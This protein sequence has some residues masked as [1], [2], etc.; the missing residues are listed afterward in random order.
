M[1]ESD[2]NKMAEPVLEPDNALPETTLETLPEAVREAA[3]R[4]GWP[5][6]M[7]VQAKAIPYLLQRRDL[8]VQSRTGSGKTG[9]YVLPMV[10]QLDFASASCQALVLTPTREL[11]HQVAQAAT[12]LFGEGGLHVVSVYG[13]AAYGPQIEGFKRGA[14]LVVGTPGRILDHL[15]RGTLSLDGL[16]FLVFDEA[17]RMLSMGFYPDMRRIQSF[18]PRRRVHGSMF[19]ATYP[20][21]VLRLAEEFLDHPGF[22]SLS[23]DHVHV[24]ETTHLFTVCPPMRKDRSLV[25]I[26]EVENP[27]SAII[28]CNTRENVGFVTTVLQRFGYDADALSADLTQAAR[29][30][31]MARLRE[32][33]LRFLVATD[34]AARGIDI[35]ELSHVIQYEPGED[36]ESYVHRSGRTGRAGAAGT[37]ITLVA[38]MEEIR[39]MEIARA[40]NL[41]MEERPLPTD[42]EVEALV[43]Q[44]VTALLESEFRALDNIRKERLKRFLPLARSLE[45][46]ADETD[47]V[48]ML[49]DN[50]YQRSLH[51]PETPPLGAARPPAPPREHRPRR[52]EDRSREGRD[53]RPPRRR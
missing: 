30:K 31:V 7:P 1:T 34:V 40:Y 53:R 42:E 39:L 51:G 25:K 9:A 21:Y 19:S 37:A 6:L 52:S 43:A 11:A 48:A 24:A 2:P 28:F 12:L 33:S 22:L 38:G 15:I 5:A 16:K 46:E 18:L 47:L 29:E 20:P 13:G 26:L 35:P 32:G 45:Q 36:P 27:A 17:D 41:P 49:L 10:H 4:A 14:H 50:Y 8:M 44:R 3:A 23:K